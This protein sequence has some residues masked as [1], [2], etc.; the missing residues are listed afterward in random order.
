MA[1]MLLIWKQEPAVYKQRPSL[2][3]LNPS[4]PALVGHDAFALSLSPCSFSV[5]RIHGRNIIVQ[6]RSED[7]N[8]R[9]ATIHRLAD[10]SKFD[11]LPPIHGRRLKSCIRRRVNPAHVPE[12]S[13]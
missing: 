10:A 4:L 7:G 8:V 3:L 1:L 2:Y 13:R 5:P 11:R 9:S 6:R 12:C